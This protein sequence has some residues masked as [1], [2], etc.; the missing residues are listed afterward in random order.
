MAIRHMKRYSALLIIR[1]MQV[2][3]IMRCLLTP[4]RMAVIKNTTNNKC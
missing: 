3:T 2:K 1:E 4:V